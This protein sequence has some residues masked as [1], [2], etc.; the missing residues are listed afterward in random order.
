[1]IQEVKIINFQSHKETTLI[2]DKGMN[3]II[4]QSDC[5]KTAIIR[6]LKWVIENR[7][8]GDAFRSD[9]GGDTLVQLVTETD[10]IT[11]IKTK[12][13]NS[14][15]LNKTKFNAFSTNVPE[16]IKKAL[17]MDEVNLQQQ[18]DS[19][20]LI[21]DT[22]G[23]V[24]THFNRIAKLDKIDRGL[25]NVQKE[26]KLITSNITY[27]KIEIK[28]KAELLEEFVDL[29]SFEKELNEIEKFVKL[30]ETLIK[31]IQK[32]EYDVMTLNKL[33]IS[34][35]KQSIIL[36]MEKSVDVILEMY[37]DVEAIHQNYIKIRKDSLK[38][39]YLKVDIETAEASILM[40]SSINR[41]LEMYEKHTETT[42]KLN[43]LDELYSTIKHN[44]KSQEKSLKSILK[45][46]K[47]FYKNFPAICPLCDTEIHGIEETPIT[48]ESIK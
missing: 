21:S 4:G 18:M 25:S 17:N 48:W 6:A 9:W 28:R 41:I 22:S 12:S 20:F 39:H 19:P 30:K 45:L 23:N 44:E 37:E 16:E 7:P 46:E 10:E 27:T 32:G 38:I 8:N 26:I 24:A 40:E 31:D 13:E 2:F 34:I 11:R 43:E 14:Y 3:V 35:D 1:M 42:Q 5:G 47:N 29:E 36:E 15:Q 33:I